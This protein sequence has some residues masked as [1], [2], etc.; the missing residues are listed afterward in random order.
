MAEF[1]QQ[2]K[3]LFDAQRFF[4]DPCLEAA[5]ARETGEQ[6][7]SCPMMNPKLPLAADGPFTGEKKGGGGAGGHA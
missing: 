7:K 4:R 2:L 1:K 3:L 5:I 6:G